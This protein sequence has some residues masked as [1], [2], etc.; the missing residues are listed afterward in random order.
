VPGSTL[1]STLTVTQDCGTFP[2]YVTVQ[3]SAG[4]AQT[5]SYDGSNLRAA[6]SRTVGGP[7]YGCDVP[8]ISATIDVSV[9]G[10]SGD[11]IV[12]EVVGTASLTSGYGG[13]EF[14]G[15]SASL[16]TYDIVARRGG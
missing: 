7:Q 9:T 6:G 1:Q 12:L 4:N 13:P 5:G 15:C 10:V 3:T 14:D 11:N 8:Y 16:A 2:C